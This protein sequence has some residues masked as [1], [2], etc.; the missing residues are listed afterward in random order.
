MPCKNKINVKRKKES[1][2]NIGGS[3]IHRNNANT[4]SLKCSLNIFSNET[5]QFFHSFRHVKQIQ[6]RESLVGIKRQTSEEYAATFDI[7]REKATEIL[8]ANP[9]LR[10]WIV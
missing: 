8:N 10:Q 5:S 4:S 1:N 7:P 2:N 9:I 3:I 6:D